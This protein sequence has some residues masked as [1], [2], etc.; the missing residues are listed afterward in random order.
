MNRERRVEMSTAWLLVLGL[1]IAWSACSKGS[2]SLTLNTSPQPVIELSSKAFSF[3]A[4]SGGPNPASQVVSISNTGNGTLAGLTTGTISY[5]GGASAWISP[6]VLNSSTGNIAFTISLQPI[7]G[8]LAPGSYSATIPVLLAGASN[9]PQNISVTLT[10]S[11]GVVQRLTVNVAGSGTVALTPGSLASGTCGTIATATC[12]ADYVQGEA[13]VL[14]AMPAAGVAFVGW[15]GACS[16]ISTCSVTMDQARSVTATFTSNTPII[17]LSTSVLTFGATAGGS[18]PASQIITVTNGGIGTLSGLTIGSIAYGAGAFGW[19]QLPVLN[20]A[21]A[22]ATFTVQVNLGALGTGTYTATIPIAS[23]IASN[24]PRTVTVSLVVAPQGPAISLSPEILVY[25]GPWRGGN[26]ASQ[27][28]AITNGGGGTLTGLSVGTVSY[29]PGAFGWIQSVTLNSPSATA[30][31]TVQPTIGVLDPGVYTALIPVQSAVASNSPRSATATLT[32][33]E[34]VPT[35]AKLFV[36]G[37]EY[38][39]AVE[40]K[41]N[42]TYSMEVR[43]YEADGSQMT[44]LPPG[45]LISM[46]MIFASY[47]T[48]GPSAS[49]TDGFHFTAVIGNSSYGGGTLTIYYGTASNPTTRRLRDISLTVS[50]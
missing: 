3:N 26:P 48:I 27:S 12:S 31:L 16:G 29:G 1:P 33:V 2:G 49:V 8:T 18:N 5:G 47:G 37:V 10:L 9:S 42:T 44:R 23:T 32:V 25:S 46:T 6:P 24:S 45:K 11:A 19:L 30:L 15:S 43:L 41:W 17:T 13:V 34:P 35:S 40:F 21:T 36:N 22:P 39:T 50:F 28:L 7:A 20:T 4:M 38:P 14:T